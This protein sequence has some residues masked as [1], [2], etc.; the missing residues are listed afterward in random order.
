MAKLTF[1][2]LLR[3]AV[4]AVGASKVPIRAVE[5]D[6]S[7]KKLR[8]EF[9]REPPPAAPAALMLPGSATPAAAGMPFPLPE[10]KMVAG[11]TIPD[12]NSPVSD[13]DI[14][15]A[16]PQ[17]RLDQEQRQASADERAA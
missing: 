16:K 17:Y 2:G 14:V 11:T 6:P 3:D 1:K 5:Y 15:L 12:D 7:T 10:V 8:V 4:E 9:D 13:L